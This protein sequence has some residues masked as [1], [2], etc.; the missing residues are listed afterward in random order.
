MSRFSVLCLAAITL[1]SPAIAQ[2]ATIRPEWRDTTIESN[3]AARE[4]LEGKPPPSL[5]GLSNW[6][7]TDARSWKDLRGKVVLIDVWATWCGPC[8]RGIPHLKELNDKY[9]DDGLVILGVHSA[10]GWNKMEGYVKE[11]KLPWSFAAD[12]ERTLGKKLGIAYIPSYFFID[13]RGVMRVAYANRQKLEDISRALLGE[14]APA[15]ESK[16]SLAAWP[17]S[18]DKELYAD[19]VRG[20]KAPELVVGQ[21]LSDKPDTEGKVV[22]IDFWAT[23][24]GPCR[25]AIPELESIQQEFADDLVVIGIS[26]EKPEK[27]EKFLAKSPI[28]YATAVD[29][30]ARMKSAIHV[31][32]IPHLLIIST[33]GV[34]RWQ[35]FPGS[36]KEPL[37]PAI[38]RQIINADP[39]VAKRHA[40]A[41]G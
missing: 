6:V 24:C 33:D 25:K 19:D 35:G 23:W 8:I 15:S 34:V 12:T 2:K 31:R 5:E 13:R 20:K 26:D 30:K 9:A 37:T 28:A 16:S 21:W 18:V 4:R 11:K 17:V 3:N 22:L 41:A 1:V 14:P 39:G 38:V 29:T 32:G 36:P 7:Q 40:S 27:V 10:R